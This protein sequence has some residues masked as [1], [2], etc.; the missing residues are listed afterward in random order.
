M[1]FIAEFSKTEGISDSFDF[2]GKGC[3]IVICGLFDFSRFQIS[4][5]SFPLGLMFTLTQSELE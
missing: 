4:F 5:Q 3:H 1:R 2:A